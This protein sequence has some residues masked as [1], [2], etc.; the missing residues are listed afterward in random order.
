MG[1]WGEQLLL[2]LK[3][4]AFSLYDVSNQKV[5]CPHDSCVHMTDTDLW[6]DD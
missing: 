3:W 2:R 6:A 1:P 4:Q 5:G